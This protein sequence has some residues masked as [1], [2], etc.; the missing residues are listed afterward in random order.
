MFRCLSLVSRLTSKMSWRQ[1]GWRRCHRRWRVWRQ[2]S[3][4][5]PTLTHPQPSHPTPVSSHPLAMESASVYFII[6]FGEL[7]Q[8]KYSKYHTFKLT[9]LKGIFLDLIIDKNVIWIDHINYISSKIASNIYLLRNYSKCSTQSK[10]NCLL[11]SH[12]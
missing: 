12:I 8:N 6:I 2:H 4:C 7:T 3:S 1:T 9:P 11:W 5:S 10:I